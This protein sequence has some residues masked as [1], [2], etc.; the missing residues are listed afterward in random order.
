MRTIKIL[1]IIGFLVFTVSCTERIDLELDSSFTR[2]VIYG[3]ITTDTTSHRV[4]VTRTG[5]YFGQNPPVGI[6]GAQVT[7]FDGENAFELTEGDEPGVYYTEPTVFGIPGR[8]YT[9]F[10]SNVDLLGDGNLKNYEAFSELKPISEA[11]SINVYYRAE[12]Q[13][14]VIQAWATDPAETKDFY[15]FH[16]YVNGQ[17]MTDSLR[18]IIVTDDQFFNGSQTNGVVIGYMFGE[19]ALS[20]NDTVTVGFCGI[21]ED[22]YK[23]IIEAQTTARPSSPLFSSAPANPRTNLSN[24]ALGYFTAYSIARSTK[25]IRE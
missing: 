23:Y 22:F 25:I 7:I 18:N 19:D 24:D 6:S 21:T 9:L 17:L 3:E 14:W 16:T 5:D 10:V 1:P 20:V 4:I 11:D 12:W 2:C 8:T 13:G 15:M